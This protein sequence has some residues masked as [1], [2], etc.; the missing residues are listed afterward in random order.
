MLRLRAAAAGQ[1]LSDYLLR[2]LSQIARQ[3]T[4]E[5]LDLPLATADRALKT[6]RGFAKR[7]RVF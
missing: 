2:E 3:L 5:A 7:V 4:P 6:I 1:S